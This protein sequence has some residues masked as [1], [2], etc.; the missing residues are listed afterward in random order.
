MKKDFIYLSIILLIIGFAVKANLKESTHVY[1]EETY[2]HGLHYGIWSRTNDVT[3]L[4]VRCFEVD[5][6]QAKQTIDLHDY[7]HIRQ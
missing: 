7:F 3:P 1:F 6:A 4:V 5:S 2:R